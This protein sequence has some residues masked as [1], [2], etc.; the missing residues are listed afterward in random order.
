MGSENGENECRGNKIKSFPNISGNC[1]AQENIKVLLFKFMIWFLF[2]EK[3][4]GVVKMNEFNQISP[5]V[6]S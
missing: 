4:T 3:T 5:N 2:L 1:F 6:F